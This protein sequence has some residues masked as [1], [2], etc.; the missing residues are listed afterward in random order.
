[1]K[2]EEVFVLIDSKKVA[3]KLSKVL[4]MFNEKVFTNPDHLNEDNNG[5]S[6]HWRYGFSIG[7]WQG[8]NLN[9]SHYRNI[10]HKEVSV[11]ELK[12][13]LAM[14]HLKKGDVVVCELGNEKWIVEFSHFD[15][16][17]PFK[18]ISFKWNYKGDTAESV[19]G[20]YFDK[21][22]RYA[23]EE[24]KQLLNPVKKEDEKHTGSFE[25]LRKCDIVDFPN[26]FK[27]VENNKKDLEV[28]KWYFVDRSKVITNDPKALVMYQGNGVSTFGFNHNGTYINDYGAYDTFCNPDYQYTKST[29]EEVAERFFKECHK[30][31]PNKIGFIFNHSTNEITSGNEIVFKNGTWL[32]AKKIEIDPFKELKEAH[33]KGF[34][35]EYKSSSGQWKTSSN[36]AWR[37]TGNYRIR[38]RKIGDW[39]RIT[40]SVTNVNAYIQ[41]N[42]TNINNVNENDVRISNQMVIDILNNGKYT[43]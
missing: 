11:S 37:K 27:E 24:E 12:K 32:E 21:F 40:N 3:K 31:Y 15:T 28:G 34:E 29:Q 16:V 43:V 42:E 1:M 22:I 35:I 13:I 39:F 33:K 9:S 6:E 5:K 20:G 36:P 38:P 8:K 19:R 18:L 25:S 14:E 10:E 7:M 30:R 4:A 41:I 23:T 2:K 26:D 17:E